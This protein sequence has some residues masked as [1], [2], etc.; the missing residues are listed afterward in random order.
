MARL[1]PRAI[2]DSMMKRRWASVGLMVVA[3]ATAIVAVLA[4]ALLPHGP[5]ESERISALGRYD[6]YSYAD[7]NGWQREAHYVSVRD[8]TLLAVDIYRPT[9]WGIPAQKRLP[10]LWS[11]VRYYRATLDGEEMQLPVQQTARYQKLLKNGYVLAFVDVRGSGAS[12]GSNDGPFSEAEANDAYDIT[13]WLARQPW[14]NGRIG[15][16]GTSYMGIAQY[17]AA[18]RRPPSLKAIFPEKAMFDLYDFVRPGGIL[19]E[20]FGRQWSA[21]VGKLDEEVRA[22]P[23]STDSKLDLRAA[24][25]RDHARSRS[26]FDLLAPLAYRDATDARSGERVFATRSPG[27]YLDAINAS[28]VAIYHLA[29]WL[30]MW[31]RD[32]L[33]WFANIKTPQKLVIGPWSH[34]GTEDFDNFAEHLRWY[35]FWL[36]GIENGVMTEPRIS[37]YTMGAPKGREWRATN[38]WPLS[39]EKRVDLFFCA[40]STS[41]PA[42]PDAGGLCR[43]NPPAD[44]EEV[45]LDVNATSGKSTR[46][47]NGYNRKISYGDLLQ[48][49]AR[50]KI[51][52]SAALEHDVEVT[53]HPIVRIWLSTEQPA[54]DLVAYLQ[55][56]DGDGAVTYVTEGVLRLSHRAVEEPPYN[57]LGLPYHRGSAADLQAAP[58]KTTEVTF[59]LLPI[60]KVFAGGNR[61]RI[62]LTGAD[63]DN[64]ERHP[65]GNGTGIYIFRGVGHP[66]ALDLPIIGAV[67]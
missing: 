60:S 66:S 30:D 44:K 63:V 1:R 5:P 42:N 64:L 46:W 38:V 37:Y 50:G 54:V 36:K 51:Y 23:G 17:F 2:A 55:E 56:V 3:A 67:P 34:I 62:T 45:Y 12:L 27:A 41:L 43:T 20:D 11:H 13:E 58:A 31:P 48:G 53:G 29:G 47:S 14:S 18:A 59:D 16:F 22:P 9:Y 26:A 52:E 28:G 35:D 49:T 65:P 21:I 33:I 8:G 19:R 10:V 39:D 32:A 7:Y 6:G 57:R 24:A 15:M 4:G 61:I 25:R 40:A